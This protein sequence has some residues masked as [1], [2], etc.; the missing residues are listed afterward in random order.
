MNISQPQS[1]SGV[2]RSASHRRIDAD[3]MAADWK[4]NFEPDH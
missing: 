4:D 3:R 2:Q 1:M